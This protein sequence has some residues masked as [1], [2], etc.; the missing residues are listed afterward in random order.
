[1]NFLLPDGVTV[2]RMD[3]PEGSVIPFT[4]ISLL[5]A[6]DPAADFA[7]LK[8]TDIRDISFE[9]DVYRAS[10]TTE[11]GGML[12]IPLLYSGNWTALVNGSPA[13]VENINGGLIGVYLPAGEA[14]VT[15]TYALPKFSLAVSVSLI[16]CGV[17]VV[18]FI[19][20]LFSRK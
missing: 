6:P 10:V 7:A 20:S 16:A 17:W 4:D 11:N 3:I 12:C 14:D 1:M 19:L 5:T 15:L 13:P 2:I 9:N 18:L 8:N